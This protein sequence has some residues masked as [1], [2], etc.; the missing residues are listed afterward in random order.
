MKFRRQRLDRIAGGALSFPASLPQ[1]GEGRK[2]SRRGTVI[3]I[4]LA[5]L[6]ALT[7]MGVLIYSI[8]ASEEVSAEYF[9]ESAKVTDPGLDP[10][11][12][13]N[14]TI[15]Q[16]LIGPDVN[17][18]QS[19]LWGGRLSMVPNLFGRDFAPYSGEGTNLAFVG[20][21]A[22]VDR[23][24]DGVNDGAPASE[25]LKINISGAAQP[26]GANG[27]PINI[28][29]LNNDGTANDAYPEPDAGYTS[30]DIN[31]P[32]LS[33]DALVPN[34]VNDPVRVVVPSFHRPQTLR[35]VV[36]PN[37]WYSDPTTKALVLHPHIEHLA[38]PS[39]WS[40]GTDPVPTT[41]RFV[42][43]TYPEAGMS[44][45]PFPGDPGADLQP[46]VASVDDDGVNGIDDAG[47]LGFPGSDDGPPVGA[48]GVWTGTDNATAV[49]N[50][51]NINYGADPDGDGV[52]DAFWMDFGFPIM[53]IP[54][55]GS[56]FVAMGTV[57]IEDLDDKFNVNAHGNA[58][59]DLTFDVSAGQFGGVGEFISKSNQGSGPHAVNPEWTRNGRPAPV[60]YTGPDL[61]AA[62]EQHRLEFRDSAS[63][64]APANN[65]TGNH[66][67]NDFE[68]AN[69]EWLRI[70]Q[71]GATIIDPGAGV[72][73]SASDITQFVRGRWEGNEGRLVPMI[74]SRNP[75]NAPFAGFSG[76][77]DNHNGTS[78]PPGTLGRDFDEGGSWL[79]Q[80]TS[81]SYP[82]FLYPF[83]F[84]GSGR[85]SISLTV[86]GTS[87]GKKRDL[88]TFVDEPTIGNHA[89]AV[90]RNYK[91]HPNVGLFSAGMPIF[92]AMMPA[93][94]AHQLVDDPAETHLEPAL[95]ALQKED[96]IYG[97]GEN[98]G[99]LPDTV[100]KN[101]LNTPGSLAKVASYN[102]VDN[103][104]AQEIRKRFTSTSFDLK[105]FGKTFFGSYT[106]ADD[107]FRKWE[108]TD[109]SGVGNGPFVFP[110]SFP[111][112]GAQQTVFPNAP[113]ALQPFRQE[114]FELLRS[115][116]IDG[117]GSKPI[118]RLLSV[119][120][121]LDRN[122]ST[123]RLRFR[124]LTP[125]PTGLGNAPVA[126]QPAIATAEQLTA[127]NLAQQE[128]LAR[129]DRQRM[130]RDIYVLLYT[131]G[132]GSDAVNYTG[133]NSGRALH[134]NEQ[135]QEMAQFAVN[136]VDALDPDNVI[137]QFVYDRNLG[138]GW[139]ID[140][141]RYD[142]PD[143]MAAD[144]DR[145]VVYGVE[146][147]M[148]ALNEAMILLGKR[149][150]DSSMMPFNHP[151]TE[152]DDT[153]HRSFV[154]L[155]LEN[156]SPFP[157]DFINDNWQILIKPADAASQPFVGER[158][159]TLRSGIG[160][161]A[162]GTNS[163]FTIGAVGDA[164][165]VD[166]MGNPRPSYF[167]VAPDAN[168]LNL[169]RIS[170]RGLF[171]LDLMVAPTNSRYRV[172]QS[173]DP[174][175]KGD[176]PVVNNTNPLS[177]AG[178][179]LL[180][181]KN[182]TDPYPNQF[183]TLSEGT[184]NIEI[185]LR[186]RA[187][188]SR[189]EPSVYNAGDMGAAHLAET[190]DNPWIVVDEM[191]VPLEIFE[192]TDTDA[193]AQIEPKLSAVRSKE[194]LQPL[195]GGVVG[196]DEPVDGGQTTY[197]TPT[198]KGNSFGEVNDAATDITLP[199]DGVKDYTLWQPHFDRDFAS[200]GELFNVPLWGSFGD[201]TQTND[202]QQEVDKP[203]IN[204][205]AAVTSL[206][207]LLEGLLTRRLGSKYGETSQ[208]PIAVSLVGDDWSAAATAGRKPGVGTAGYRI[209][210]PEGADSAQPNPAT[211]LT[212]NRWHRA[213][214]FLEVPSR[215]ERHLDNPPYMIDAGKIDVSA[216]LGDEP[217]GIY[218]TAGKM[219]LNTLRYPENL[220]GLLDDKDVFGLDLTSVAGTKKYLPDRS[221]EVARDWWIQFVG[222][223]N[224][225]DPITN[226]LLPGVPSSP[227]NVAP[228]G[229]HP[230]RG[231]G[232]SQYG[233]VHVAT[234]NGT[235]ENT[236]L[237]SLFPDATALSPAPDQR[238]RLF[239]LGTNPEHNNSGV[240]YAMKH[241]LLSK[242]MNN[243]TTRSN[244][245]V[246][247]IEVA[248]FEA[249][250]VLDGATGKPVVRVGG[251]IPSTPTF[252]TSYRGFF[253]VDRSKAMEL[254]T[255][256][257][258][259]NASAT[260]FI[261]SFNQNFNYRSLVLFQRTIPE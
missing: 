206:P 223:R 222:A 32:F 150:V 79:Y 258:L 26:L 10:N 174:T 171:N 34:G 103:S 114:L 19:A 219:N 37:L 216:P 162:A 21:L 129:Y 11:S 218:R 156:V 74:I 241:R 242:L 112:A 89:W 187:N 200:V 261:S 236:V 255:P 160:N 180:D 158:R 24:F 237:R 246:I 243:T 56:K 252:K 124:P 189:A 130:A 9:A 240:D 148:L 84:L 63:R 193:Q 16:I 178:I 49:T 244:T 118:Q 52:N 142:D 199:A 54:G 120:G 234:H 67:A 76:T 228:T 165:N 45:F 152:Y 250:E 145:G 128:W 137:T 95:A 115:P 83:D 190:K 259:P 173:A 191:T 7:L 15:R 116:N 94:V 60:D 109:V 231:L 146:R 44:N 23:N 155:E 213:L 59:G 20:G 64:G 13:F 3:V 90:H 66:E 215:L 138:D 43:A 28:N 184:V 85:T 36:A 143:P 57:K 196:V 113:S 232:F 185:Q 144:L 61:N 100:F 136:V 135:L 204:T 141:Y 251:R 122:P 106:G 139:D 168:P 75:A 239:E 65:P 217:L 210:H 68:L 224:G 117:S 197:L 39:D 25:L 132:G 12:F 153:K 194:R 260:P 27:N 249:K 58:E 70:L 205:T 111:G 177:P 42:S 176:G 248:F 207:S 29:D 257:D 131:L 62:L 69:M 38:L 175:A 30:W 77:D 133:D 82:A 99:L 149:V 31:S 154:H 151:A 220:A 167:M 46:G 127:G 227:P 17:E 51:A 166:G 159:L 41:R 188:L 181:L 253:V 163:R 254:L 169:Q 229:S 104:R 161:I 87:F 73:L 33:H 5:L 98:Q 18:R 170:P 47:E 14:F 140:D 72:A 230:F 40:P 221:G 107:I 214:A 126:Y 80:G 157:V 147:Q 186:R 35:G 2:N 55:S 92:N 208:A 203:T 245:F 233:D 182:L 121:V 192:L 164:E 125:H 209:L 48:E 88:A 91:A 81:G 101:K 202:G 102:F 211:D 179:E 247:F 238:R 96:S 8:S 78:I 119:N 226:L 225:I 108:F 212:E 93:A 86:D 4:V 6:G 123:G 198:F 105:A 172:T 53:E 71:G 22:V 50:A 195:Y 201:N 110:P 235:L 256:A 134:T 1:R 183:D 97:A